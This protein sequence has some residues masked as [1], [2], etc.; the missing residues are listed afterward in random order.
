MEEIHLVELEKMIKKC[1]DS[2]LQNDDNSLENWAKLVADCIEHRNIIV[3]CNIESG[4]NNE[5][6]TGVKG[7]NY[8]I[9]FSSVFNM[10]LI[11]YVL[12]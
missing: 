3:V 7:F 10:R 5:A 1:R 9:S 8:C 12:L 6:E 4:A 2:K 11:Y